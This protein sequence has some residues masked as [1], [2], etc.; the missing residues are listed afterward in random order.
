MTRVAST[1]S[2]SVALHTLSRGMAAHG[3][4]TGGPPDL[5]DAESEGEEALRARGPGEASW[6]RLPWRGEAPADH[7]RHR[8]SSTRSAARLD[9]LRRRS[10]SSRGSGRC[11]LARTTRELRGGGGGG[12]GGHGWQ[13]RQ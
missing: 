9:G 5:A 13:Q 6:E 1:G 4:S 3:F 11:C 12:G 8:S 7:S 2:V 10:G